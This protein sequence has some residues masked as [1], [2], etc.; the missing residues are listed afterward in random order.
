MQQLEAAHAV[1]TARDAEIAARD[2]VIAAR[3]AEIAA[4]EV[5]TARAKLHSTFG[6]F[7]ILSEFLELIDECKLPLKSPPAII[8]NTSMSTATRTGAGF[9]WP[10]M[11]AV[12]QAAAWLQKH[13]LF[14]SCD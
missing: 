10:K 6:N 9:T 14:P 8:A 3:D 7:K 11:S 12:L 4:Q 5:T 13:W 1:I 2:A